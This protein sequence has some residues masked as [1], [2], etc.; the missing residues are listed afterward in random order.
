MQAICRPSVVIEGC[1][2][3]AACESPARCVSVGAHVYMFT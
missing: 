1:V 3:V 2:F